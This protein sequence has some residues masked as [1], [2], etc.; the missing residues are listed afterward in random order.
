MR[1]RTVAGA[2]LLFVAGCYQPSCNYQFGNCES[3]FE[4]GSSQI[5][6]GLFGVCEDARVCTSDGS[7]EIGESCVERTGNDSV[8]SKPGKSVCKC[9]SGGC[10]EEGGYGGEGG[11]GG[12]GGNGGN[13][14]S[15]GASPFCD[16]SAAP[17]GLPISNAQFG[18]VEDQGGP[19]L[20]TALGADRLIAMPFE[21]ALELGGTG[22]V[23]AGDHDIA[24]ARINAEG[25]VVWARSFGDA[26]AQLP[27]AIATQGDNVVV[28]ISFTG[29]ID[30]GTGALAAAGAGSAAA[31]F[32]LDSTGK[33]QWAKLLTGDGDVHVSSLAVRPTGEVMVAG[34]FTGE[35]DTGGQK[36]LSVDA[37]DGFLAELTPAGDDVQ[38][39]EVVGGAGEQEVSSV[40]LDGLGSTFLAV[41]FDGE[42]PLGGDVFTS[43]GQ[44]IFVMRYLDSEQLDWA[45]LI[46]GPERQVATGLAVDPEYGVIVTGVRAS[47]TPSS[48]G[49]D[50]GAG[51]VP[52]VGLVDTFVMKLNA[53]GQ[54]EW[55]QVFGGPADTGEAVPRAVVT[56]CAG[57][58]VVAGS[59]TAGADFGGGALAGAGGRDAFVFKLGRQG[60]YFWSRAFGGPADDE[61]SGLALELSAALEPGTIQVS[62]SFAGTAD[63]GLG[64]LVSAGKDDAFLLSLTP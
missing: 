33:T 11:F 22:L 15:G 30:V 26:S 12:S 38:W 53:G 23:S 31:V 37:T 1:L 50:F 54:V 55:G 2:V 63:L 62:G 19:L 60:E 44:D 43:D 49:I 56:D 16:G 4:C 9:L 25:A 13:G 48:S 34:S 41:S 3:D 29:T 42:I 24:V 8:S 40:A 18:G 57:N 21:G 47:L 58:I 52:G 45:R 46:G 17:Q 27:T 32:A 59:A 7:C 35:L 20:A 39:L 51:L 6:G 5:C 28:A 10:G 61:A 64:P 14:G 36:V